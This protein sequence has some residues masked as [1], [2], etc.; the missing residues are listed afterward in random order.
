MERLLT[1]IAGAVATTVALALPVGYFSTV[2]HLQHVTLQTGVDGDAQ[3]L[4]LMLVS[5][6]KAWE[7]EAQRLHW[8]LGSPTYSDRTTA[9]T[10]IDTTGRVLAEHVRARTDHPAFTNS[11]TR[12]CLET[13][14]LFQSS[15]LL[16][17]VLNPRVW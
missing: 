5:N 16:G 14:C 15:Q 6:P 3:L 12:S 9:H 4:R 8:E 13:S 10:L 1:T 2:Y 17:T 7:T 11:A